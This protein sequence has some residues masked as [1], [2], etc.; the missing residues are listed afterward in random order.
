MV[1][2]PECQ[3][4]IMTG[5]G[6]MCPACSQKYSR[7]AGRWHD[8]MPKCDDPAAALRELVELANNFSESTSRY[9]GNT[10]MVR[11]FRNALTPFRHLLGDKPE[12]QP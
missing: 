11:M 6:I 3:A 4:T 5:G 7:K 9:E 1:K 10:L 8:V 2:C 12:V